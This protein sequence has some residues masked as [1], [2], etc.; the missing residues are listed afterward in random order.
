[1][2]ERLPLTRSLSDRLP[3]LECVLTI[4][5]AKRWIDLEAAEARL[6]FSGT[7]L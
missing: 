1:M 2:R 7:A 4:G 6:T 5:T 3:H